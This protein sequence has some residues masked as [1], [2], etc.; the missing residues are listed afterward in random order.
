MRLLIIAA[1][2]LSTGALHAATR[3]PAPS[4]LP[5]I[6]AFHKAYENC[7]RADPAHE[8]DTA[9]RL[10]KKLEGQGFC[11]RGHVFVGQSSKDGKHCYKMQHS[12][13]Y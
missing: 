12:I 13:P 1:L 5:T 3:T 9:D 10:Q 4:A 8:C 11:I 7:Y 6:Y 2:L